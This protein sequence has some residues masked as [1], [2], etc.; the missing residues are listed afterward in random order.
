MLGDCRI[1]GLA[2]T[3]HD[4]LWAV[5]GP[6]PRKGRVTNPAKLDHVSDTNNT[7]SERKRSGIRI[8]DR[9]GLMAEN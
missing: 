6:S 9:I 7:R 5:S 3:R 1:I 2:A 8:Q 4:Q